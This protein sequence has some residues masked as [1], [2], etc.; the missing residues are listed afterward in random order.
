MYVS[1]LLFAKKY[2]I[3]SV[4]RYA[5]MYHKWNPNGFSLNNI[6]FLNVDN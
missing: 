5:F 3:T 6:K 1:L 4:Y 2:I